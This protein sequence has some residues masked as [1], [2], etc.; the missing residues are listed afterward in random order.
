MLIVYLLPQGGSV[1]FVPEALQV[2]RLRCPGATT[3]AAGSARTGRTARPA[4]GRAARGS[5][6]ALVGRAR[7]R[8]RGA[9]RSSAARRNSALVR[10][11]R[12]RCFSV[13]L[14]CARGRVGALAHRGDRV[15]ADV[16]GSSRSWSRRRPAASACARR[17]PAAVA[18]RP[19][20]GHR[21]PRARAARSAGPPGCRRA[22]VAA[23]DQQR[24]GAVGADRERG[25]ALLL[26]Q[27]FAMVPGRAEVHRAVGVGT[28]AR[29]SARPV[30][31]R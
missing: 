19:R 9:P 11:A 13:G 14:G 5:G 15:A 20:C 4:R 23:F 30:G 28:S 7:H 12:G 26:A 27:R 16:V 1:A 22:D 17:A 10:A 6:D 18:L 3:T 2:G 21:R 25:R 29:R 24:I 8:P 31:W